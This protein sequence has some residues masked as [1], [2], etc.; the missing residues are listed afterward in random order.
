MTLRHQ[1]KA[2][3]VMSTTCDHFE[4]QSGTPKAHPTSNTTVPVP[5]ASGFRTI[6]SL[7]TQ[8]NMFTD[9]I[10]ISQVFILGELLFGDCHNDLDKGVYFFTPGIQ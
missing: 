10:N 4:I 8:Q 9:H 6:L 2:L 7:A 1:N 3:S 5:A